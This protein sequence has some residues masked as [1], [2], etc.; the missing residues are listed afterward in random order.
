VLVC[1]CVCVVV[2]VLC[3]MSERFVFSERLNCFDW[4]RLHFDL[5]IGNLRIWVRNYGFVFRVLRKDTF[6]ISR[7]LLAIEE[8]L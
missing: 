8:I 6:L 4:R 1:V 2:E 7:L 5:K 3:V